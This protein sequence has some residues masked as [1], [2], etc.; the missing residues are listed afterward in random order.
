M[1]RIIHQGLLATSSLAVLLALG[2]CGQRTDTTT[3]G[4][5]AP[6]TNEQVARDTAPATPSAPPVAA[7]SGSDST[8]VLGAGSS[9]GMIDDAQIVTKVNT[10]IAA[11][12]DLSTFK[13]DVDSK[14]GMVVL[15][16]TV[17]SDDAKRRAEDIAKNVKDVK[18]VENQLSVKAG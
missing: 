17:P 2:A 11:D 16:G 8:S 6:A 4:E 10:G 15:K 12:K 7:N 18:S 3:T 14:G 9:T 1:K 13:I 5:K